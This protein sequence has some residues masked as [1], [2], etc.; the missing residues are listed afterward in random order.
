MAE[1]FVLCQAPVDL[2]PR[3]SRAWVQDV[4]PGP[5]THGKGAY[6]KSPHH[7]GKTSVPQLPVFWV[8]WIERLTDEE[9][10]SVGTLDTT[11]GWTVR[12]RLF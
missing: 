8:Q 11:F 7:Q 1:G 10:L 3:T 9:V 4:E 12:A 2:A 6:T 5:A